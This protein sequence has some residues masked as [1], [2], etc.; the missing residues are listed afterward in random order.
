MHFIIIIIKSKGRQNRVVQLKLVETQ[1]VRYFLWIRV[2]V[3]RAY[4]CNIHNN[5]FKIMAL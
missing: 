5:V 3:Y 1:N 4:S 2:A